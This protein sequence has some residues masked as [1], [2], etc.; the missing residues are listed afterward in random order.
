MYKHLFCRVLCLIL[1]AVMVLGMLPAVSAVPAG[2]RW[3]KTDAEV[4]WD[5]TDRLIPDDLPGQTAYK[6][7]DTVRVSIVLEDAPTVQAGYATMGIGSNAGA[8]AYDRNLNRIQKRMEKT[9]SVQALDGK[10]LDV[11]WNLTL[12]SNIISA[13]VPYGKIDAIKAIDGV[14]DVVI[15]RQYETADTQTVSPDMY[16]SAG[17]IGSAPVWAAGMTG[18]G[19]RVAI[20]DTGTDTDHQ[21]FDNGA[22]LHALEQNAAEKGM[23]YEAYVASLNLLDTE[24]IASVLRNLNAY[25]RVPEDAEQFY[26]SQK[27]PFGVNYVDKSL[28]VTHDFDN[29][30]S[31]GSHVAGIAAANRYIEAD[32]A[33]VS[34]RDTV[35][36]NGVAP[37]AQII[38]LKIFGNNPGPYDSDYFAAIE[39]AIW[40]GCDS[41]NLSLGSGSPGFAENYLFADLLDFMA[42]TDTVVVISAGN[43][44]H[45]AEYTAPANLYADGVSFQTNGS[46]GSYANAFTVA[47][48][49]NDGSVDKHIQVGDSKI[50]YTETAYANR[51]IAS[52]DTSKDGSGTEYD[53][54]FIDGLG[55]PEDYAGMDLTGKVVFC[56]RGELSFSEKGNIAAELGAAAIIV[57]NTDDE[58]FGMDLT[59]YTHSAPCVSITK[60]SGD[61]VRAASTP[62]SGL[63][64]YT[65][66]VTISD[67]LSVTEYDSDYYT[68]SAFSSWGIPGSLELKP[69]ITAPG[70]MIWSVNGMDT[71]GTAYEMMSG[72]SMAAPQV[73]GMAA[74]VAEY[75]KT[76]SL[77]TQTG[78][79]VR[80]LAQSLLMSTAEPLREE[81][82]GG[83]YSILNQGAGLA[84]VDLATD[85]ESFILVDGMPDGKVKAELGDDPD[86]TGVYSF[87]FDIVNL[88]DE[89]LS[90][91]LTA[92]VF[93][94]AQFRDD[95]GSVY[96]D[97]K[98][99]SLPATAFF[100]V[101][102]VSI[103]NIDGFRCDLNGDGSTNAADADHLLEY[104]LGNEDRLHADGDVNGDGTVNSYDAH[105]LLTKQTGTFTVDVAPNGTSTVDV[106][107]E[108]TEEA[109]A[110]LDAHYP[111][112]AY[113]ESF[114]F[115]APISDSEGELHVTHS[116]PVLGY[117][118]SWTEPSMYDVGSYLEYAG[119][120]E[121]RAPY[122]YQINGTQSNVVTV[123]Y[124]DGKEYAF[125]GNPFTEEAEYLPQRN[126]FNNQTGAMLSKLCFT[127]IRNAGDSMLMLTDAET[128]EV[129]MSEEM[130]AVESAYFH[131]N[132]GQWVN[133]LHRFDLGL[134]LASYAE[135]TKLNISLI[136]A[137][138]YY[139]HYE[140]DEKGNPVGYTDWDA[141]KDGAYLTVPLTI[142]NTAP[143]IRN[144]ELGE[145]NTLQITAKDNEYIAAVALMNAAG[146]N[147]IT[148]APA[149]QTQRGTEI[150]AALNLDYVFGEEFLVAVFDYAE[151][152][153]VYEIELE[154]DNERPYFT[155]IDRSNANADNSANYVGMDANG[156]CVNL[157]PT[158]GR[159]LARAAEYVE[160]AVFEITHDNKLYVGFDNDLFGMRY[161]C[162]LDPNYEHEI[163]GFSDIAYNRA[164][165][166]LYGLFYSRKNET[167][168]PYLATIDL[169]SGKLDVLGEMPFDANTIAIDGEGNFYSTTFAA[170][171]L[172]TY[173]SDVTVTGSATFVG[174]LEGYLEGTLVYFGTSAITSMAWDH[175]T[176]ELY[177]GCTD[178]NF[179]STI[180]LKVDPS[181]AKLTTVCEYP[182]LICGLYI[183]YEPEND[184]FASTDSVDLVMMPETESTLVGNTV[185]L[186]AQIAPWNASDR[187]VTW[188]SSDPTVASVDEKGLITGLRAGTAVITATSVLDPGKSA[189]CTVTVIALDKE[190]KGLVWDEAGKVW[191]SGFNTD[192]VPAY[193]KLAGIDGLP[194]NATMVADGVLYASTLDL[195]A[196]VSGLYTV[197][198]ETFAMT[199]AGGST[200]IAYLDMAYGPGTGYGYAVYYNYIVPIDL[201]TGEYVGVWDW[202]EN[203]ASDL[204]G[205][206]YYD[207]QYN[208][209]FGADMDF[210][211]ILDSNG[212]VYLEAFLITSE[213]AGYFYGPFDGYLQNI[214]DPVDQSYFQGFYYDGGYTY[215]ARFHEA[216]DRVELIVWD[217]ED[218]GRVYTLGAFPEGIWPVCG[219]YS[220][221]EFAGTASLISDTPAPAAFRSAELAAAPA[222]QHAV[223]GMLNAASAGNTGSAAVGKQEITVEIPVPADAANGIFTARYD[224]ETLICVGVLSDADAE[225]HVIDAENGVVTLAFANRSAI[226]VGEPAA[227]LRF[228]VLTNE[229]VT[230]DIT[231]STAEL[232]AGTYDYTAKIPVEL[233]HVCPSAHFVDVS[234]DHWFHEAV[235][236]VVSAG[237]MNGMDATHFGPG[238]TMNRAQFVTV[239]YRMEGEP[240]VSNTGIFTDVP[241]GQFYTDAAYWALEAGITTGTGDGT[242]F[243]PGG[244]LTRT[245]LVTFM[246]RY[247]K[248][249]GFDTASGDLSAYRDAGQV[250]PFAV[251]AWGWAVSKGIVSGMTA[252][253]LAPL[254]LTNRAQAAV[255]FQRFDGA[256]L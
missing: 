68:M 31:H 130:G 24:E 124:G 83:F 74:L 210:F 81:S 190:L 149:N 72:T 42:T 235:D 161:L 248:Y 44:G 63:N 92:D 243:N 21:S 230:T 192:T 25:E 197:D 173:T 131:I 65:G 104:L 136:I 182:F 126:A 125:G 145:D 223:S 159:M 98:T 36:M 34:A 38:T 156:I 13:N 133:T 107:L 50:L 89:A 114:V 93:T 39:D 231:V 49:D 176:D 140:A 216:D 78:L 157:A 166:K 135:G 48:V 225:A 115:A 147:V 162:D 246:Y 79:S 127:Q 76:N 33:Y 106:T 82:T 41:V 232:N 180:L 172:Y 12:V 213:A 108:L 254:A 46:P 22:Y 206:T 17:M 118:G 94:Q 128:G 32:G 29:Q 219:L 160:G 70:G 201:T 85:A 20:I 151:N 121:T 54:I 7:T 59:D 23:S 229:S 208:E 242:T 117:Y 144:V 88:G 105:V 195:S 251:D 253:T 224:T 199:P 181:T 194:V 90:Y 255:I 142:D 177:W 67:R 137:P 111:T 198:P 196:G 238:A 165:G 141:L 222:E 236:Y 189:S 14:R 212:N 174:Y 226:P 35:F 30:S 99:R 97:T 143:E 214:G 163:V 207:T 205:I 1:A 58:S 193:E 187:T 209:E 240:K 6:P 179:G 148:S 109:R 154:L 211:L 185:Q 45:W 220:D 188:S 252:D 27:L 167:T 217:T 241:A 202:T 123:N 234:A 249:R 233:T 84:R 256:F 57:C 122:L 103:E 66:R 244:Q 169:Y 170:A 139:C 18:A 43:S 191:W 247:A 8:M 15:E 113:I 40:L 101:N 91:V 2:L 56:H 120:N 96:T 47:S 52:L 186:D 138:E 26:I 239:L 146:T 60:T 183:A 73:T 4:F 218:T 129:Y 80:H 77:D 203:L 164:D 51:P 221:G 95:N 62:V 16:T 119:G 3:K 132:I 228:A 37:D 87:S 55:Y 245:E 150:T 215:W 155:A 112:G 61:A 28:N 10:A 75:I 237:Y 102:G 86:R 171:D 71:S 110:L 116:I 178:A 153:S 158:P 11:V 250:L 64:C 19:S 134:D 100:S 5:R 69:E 53:Y 152:L 200:S 184:L 9:I 175:N 168:L 204:V 227:T